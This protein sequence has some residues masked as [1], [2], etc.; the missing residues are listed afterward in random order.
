MSLVADS[1][2]SAAEW[3]LDTPRD[4]Y[5]AALTPDF[6]RQPLGNLSLPSL[7]DPQGVA[8]LTVAQSR[9]LRGPE[10]DGIIKKKLDDMLGTKWLMQAEECWYRP[11]RPAEAAGGSA[12]SAGASPPDVALLMVDN[13][14]PFPY[15][16]PG[17]TLRSPDGWGSPRTPLT[18]SWRPTESSAGVFQ[19]ALAI[20]HIYA[21]LHGYR[22]YLENPCPHVRIGVTQ[23]D[24]ESSITP[25]QLR[26]P[27]SEWREEMQR[28]TRQVRDGHTLAYPRPRRSPSAHLQCRHRP[29][30]P[31]SAPSPSVPPSLSARLLPLT[32]PLLP[33]PAHLFLSF[34][35]PLIHS[36]PPLPRAGR[37]V[38]RP[39]RLG[40]P[41]P[42]PPARSPLDQDLG[43]PLPPPPAPVRRLPR[44][45]LL[46]HR[47]EAALFNDAP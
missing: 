7:T 34:P 39:S 45:G 28:Y 29:S 3:Y 8:A 11:P 35:P 14:A 47:G 10:I 20:N 19:L 25:Q 4:R 40:P 41:R 36:T 24:W 26:V 13:R 27:K 42:L 43:H 6:L 17:T 18:P 2:H 12:S 1:W 37:R 30:L 23:E 31:L 16:V 5:T 22:F 38:S 46:R 33:S 9:S 21:Q 15:E 44:L 32:V